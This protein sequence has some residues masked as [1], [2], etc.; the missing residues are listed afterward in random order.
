MP[1]FDFLCSACSTRF[2]FSRPFGSRKKPRCPACGSARTEKCIAPPA[3]HFKG[4]GFF[5][6]DNRKAEEKKTAKAKETKVEKKA[7]PAEETKK[8]PAGKV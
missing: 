4:S 8:N 1:T 6:T 3:I 7:S 2:E 5:V